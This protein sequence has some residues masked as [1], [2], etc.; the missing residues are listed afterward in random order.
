MAEK[1]KREIL[2]VGLGPD[3]GSFLTLAALREMRAARRLVLRTGRHGAAEV[4]R[5][6]GVSFETL[7]DLYTISED[8]DELTA[9]ACE[10]LF[11]AAREGPICY[12]VGDPANDETV[13]A[14]SRTCPEGLF[15]RVMSGV[16][17][18]DNA[19]C[20]VLAQGV[21]VANRR[22][23]SAL[24]LP[25]YR[26]DAHVPLIITEINDAY[27]AS[28]AKLWLSD[29]FPDEQTIYF[30]ADAAGVGCCV[31]SIC[32]YELDRQPHYDH[33]TAVVVPAVSVLER[34]R[35]DYEDLVRVVRRLRGI[36][37]CPWDK[38]QT[39]DSLRRYMIEEACEA[40]E[41]MASGDAGR[42]ADELGDVLLQVV[43]NSRIGEEHKAFTDRDVTSAIVRKM[44]AR[45]P[46]VFGTEKADAPE[47]VN[48]LWELQKKRERGVQ[49]ASEL[50]EDV[51]E[52]L[53]ALMR[54]QKVQKRQAAALG[55]PLDAEEARRSL[56]S[57]VSQIRDSDSLGRALEAVCRL[58]EALGLDGETS[59]RTAV[60]ERIASQKKA[61]QIQDAM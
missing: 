5:Q 29:L 46:H 15:I 61:D 17:L 30:L 57:C 19:A 4:L 56:S 10:R 39:H 42:I 13:L 25:D 11:F 18:A 34:E 53:P 3:E 31:R 14:L 37:G 1:T 26:P 6:E 20:A 44:I 52:A 2:V 12:A 60:S 35:A 27:L 50:M 41:A 55:V 33:R 8:F 22:C 32:L 47:D 54:S 40:A 45:H 21:D 23:C 43:L 58:A 24:S 16:S 48:R 51:A 49:S 9:A 59:L 38:K 7:D 36:D 28:E